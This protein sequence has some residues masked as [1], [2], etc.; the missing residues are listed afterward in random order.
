MGIGAAVAAAGALGAGASIYGA[1]T[2]AGIQKKAATSATALQQNM[3]NTT[4]DNLAPYIQAGGADINQL[5]SYLNTSPTGGPG[6]GAGLLTPFNPTEAQLENT[7]GYQFTKTQGLQAVNNSNAAVGWGLSGPGLKGIAQYATGLADQTYQ[8]QFENYLTQNQQ[9][10]NLLQQPAQIGG[11]AAL[12][13]GNIALGTGTNIGSN[14]TGA[15]NAGAAA[16]TA[17][18][19]NIANTPNLLLEYMMLNNITSGAGGSGGSGSQI[20]SWAGNQ[21]NGLN[22]GQYF[23]GVN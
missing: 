10:A 12:G 21:I 1:N 19:A 15:A 9:Q 22:L 14:I 3:F 18:A 7:P 23:P 8:Q 2:A 5:N 11:Q 16:T 17:G 4:Q 20:N 6:G 13:Q